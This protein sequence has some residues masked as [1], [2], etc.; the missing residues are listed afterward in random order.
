MNANLGAK[1]HAANLGLKL[2]IPHIP[3]V[4]CNFQI[5]KISIDFIRFI[6]YSKK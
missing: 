2:H 3:V 5:L 4:L 1:R 6:L